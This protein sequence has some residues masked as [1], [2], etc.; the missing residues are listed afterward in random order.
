MKKPN[1]GMVVSFA[2]HAAVLTYAL[3]G[4]S[5]AKT[6]DPNQ[7][8]LPVEVLTASEFDQLTKGSNLSKETAEKPKVQAKKVAAVTPDPLPPAPEARE[9]VAAS[10]PEPEAAEPPPPPEPE[11]PQPE[12]AEAPPPPPEPSP[13]PVE[14]PEPKAAET[15]PAVPAPKPVDLPKPQKKVEKKPEKK[16]EKPKAKFDPSKIASL[17]DKRD[18]GLKPREGQEVASITTAGVSSG[19]ASQL[20]LSMQSMIAAMIQEQLY[21][22]WSPPIGVTYSPDLVATITFEVT[23]EGVLM[24]APRLM[25][26]SGNPAFTSFAESAMRAVHSCTQPMRPLQLPP[27]HYSIWQNITLDFILPP[28]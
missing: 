7:E 14:K 17:I 21:A 18:P 25:S 16:P 12:K 10:P 27:E 9:D 8:P 13:E 1:A 4:F 26:S 20:S 5:N 22:C 15:P 2:A 23:Q 3:V 11:K 19:T 24:G 6:F 28:A